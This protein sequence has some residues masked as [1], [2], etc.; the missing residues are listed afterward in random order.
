ML[1]GKKT[2]IGI[3]ITILGFFGLGYL[4]NGQQL[5]ELINAGLQIVGLVMTIYG[6][7]KAHRE[8]KARGG[9]R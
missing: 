4:V 9:Y 1:D 5:G 7:H 2:W 8:L 3:I 6:N